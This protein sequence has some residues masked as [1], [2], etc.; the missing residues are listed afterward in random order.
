MLENMM[1]INYHFFSNMNHSDACPVFETVTRT[2]PIVF[3]YVTLLVDD[4]AFN[5]NQQHLKIKSTENCKHRSSNHNVVRTCI[6]HAIKKIH[7]NQNGFSGGVVPCD[8]KVDGRAL[9][10]TESCLILII[11][12]HYWGPAW[13]LHMGSLN[14]FTWLGNAEKGRRLDEE[15][16]WSP[17]GSEL[18]SLLQQKKK[19]ARE[20]AEAEI[21]KGLQAILDIPK[22]YQS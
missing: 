5:Y 18:T 22:I 3:L 15:R 21:E 14:S 8:Q 12:I 1:Y 6:M 7:T 19:D 9:P 2:N 20:T 10:N 16:P 11:Q 13:C 17:L 4:I